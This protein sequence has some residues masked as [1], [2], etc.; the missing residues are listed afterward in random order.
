MLNFTGSNED[1]R[2]TIEWCV[3]FDCFT[4][5]VEMNDGFAWVMIFEDIEADSIEE[6]LAAVDEFLAMVEAAA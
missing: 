4:G 1:T 2:Y 3:D 5:K 6:A